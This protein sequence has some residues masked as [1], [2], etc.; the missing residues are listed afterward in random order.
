MGGKTGLRKE[1][2]QNC[3]RGFAGLFSRIASK[4]ETSRFARRCFI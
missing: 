3:S 2:L 4:I 1:R